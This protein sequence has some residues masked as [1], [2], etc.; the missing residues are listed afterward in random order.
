MA[1]QQADL[2][3]LP[4]SMMERQGI[5]LGDTVR[6]LC[7]FE[8]KREI[9][10]TL[11]DFLV[12]GS[13]VLPYGQEAIYTPLGI[14]FPAG[15]D[16]T[17]QLP[18]RDYIPQARWEG[19]YDMSWN[20]RQLN[21]FTFRSM[22]FTL[23]STADLDRLRDALESVPF[24]PVGSRT[25]VRNFAVID[26]ADYISAT[27][28]MQRQIRYMNALFA[29]LYTAI[30]LIGAVSAYLLQNSRK[31]EIALMRALGVGPVRIVGTFLCEQLLLSATGVAAGTLLWY[32]FGGEISGLLLVLAGVYELCWMAGS[33]LRIL[34]ALRLKAQE[35]L[36]EPE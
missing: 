13:Y 12:A 15:L 1:G 31:L 14:T 9:S 35:L 36:A 16:T 27:Q 18:D 28:G 8:D 11:L 32:A 19:N 22:I 17:T 3:V 4:V 26:D 24:A 20:Y 5:A 6:Y 2:C 10:F 30:M 23:R 25:T 7:W 29:F 34:R 21:L 33:I